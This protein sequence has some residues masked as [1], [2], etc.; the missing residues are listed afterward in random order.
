MGTTTL[1][2]LLVKEKNSLSHEI[3]TVLSKLIFFVFI[4]AM[5]FTTR[6]GYTI[7]D[8]GFELSIKKWKSHKHFRVLFVFVPLM[9]IFQLL[10]GQA[11]TPIRN[12]EYSIV[13]ILTFSPIVFLWLLLEVGLVEEFF[14]RSLLQ[15]R[16]SNFL[17]SE[18]GGVLMSALIFGLA[19]SPGLFLR[20][21]GVDTPV[22]SSPSILMSVGYSIVVLSAAGIFLGVIWSRTRNLLF[23]PP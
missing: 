10:V 7:K 19:H 18:T 8:F 20:G 5:I 22:G 23:T 15:T 12:G 6:F 4:P 16:F 13:Q 21:A 17:K 1:A 2:D 9:I 3:I 14:F 11:A